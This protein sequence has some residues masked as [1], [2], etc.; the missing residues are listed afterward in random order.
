[1]GGRAR[2]QQGISP[3]RPWRVILLSSGTMLFS[4][5]SNFDEFPAWHQVVFGVTA[6]IAAAALAVS[7]S[8]NLKKF[9]LRS[10]T[11]SNFG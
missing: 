10:L 11:E 6:C 4:I 9:K 7:P 8:A 2:R 1:M 5:A 3:Q